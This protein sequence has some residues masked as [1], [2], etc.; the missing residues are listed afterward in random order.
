[1]QEIVQK[2]RLALGDDCDV[3]FEFVDDIEPSASGKY[4]F[5]VSKVLERDQA[6][7]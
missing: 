2:V 1:L 3:S 6:R 7:L 4:R 5:T